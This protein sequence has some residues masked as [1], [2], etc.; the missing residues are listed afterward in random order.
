[1]LLAQ[2]A[3]HAEQAVEAAGWFLE[4]AWL[5]P[6]IPGIA[7]FLIILFGK[8]LPR[9]GSELG[10]LSMVAAMVIAAG[11]ALQ[12]IDHV[13]ASHGEEAAPI[14]KDITWWESGGIRFGIGSYIDG[15]A[16]MV[17]L[18]VTFI[19]TLVQ[20]YSTEYV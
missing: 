19:S 12:W 7:F 1:M 13:N 15:L 18:L 8:R 11:T 3:E 4:N 6:L 14:I 10:I 17:L 2:E 9:G 16:A 20:V 5:I